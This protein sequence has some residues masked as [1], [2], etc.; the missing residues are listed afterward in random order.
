[1]IKTLRGLTGR[2]GSLEQ[3]ELNEFEIER[4]FSHNPDKARAE[5]CYWVRKLQARF[6][7]GD[8]D[9][10]ANAAERAKSLLW[11][12]PGQFESAEYHFYAALARTA[13]WESSPNKEQVNVAVA[14]SQTQLH[15]WA[16]SCPENFDDRV[17]LIDAEIARIEGLPL[18]AERLYDA[19]IRSARANGFVHS[20]ARRWLQESGRRNPRR[21]SR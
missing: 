18:D 12:S 6:F 17:A 7:A 15:V 13:F 21:R 1:L 19:A 4:R 11:T 5:C 14:E 9:A 16:V 20:E 2:F 8:Y 3:E 10:A